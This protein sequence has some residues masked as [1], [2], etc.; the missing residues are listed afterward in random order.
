MT[1]EVARTLDDHELDRLQVTTLQY[2]MHEANPATGLIRDKT[3]QGAPSSIAAVGLALATLP[4]LV[5]R[6]VIDREFAPELALKRLR[7]FR[8]APQGMQRDASGYRGFYY[9]FLHMKTGR[10]VWDCELSTL[11]SA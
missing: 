4:V 1:T 6:G 11:D 9:H 8:D 2:Y 7:F 5:E 10:R 3:Q